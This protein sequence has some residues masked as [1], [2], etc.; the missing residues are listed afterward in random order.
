MKQNN[1]KALI[2]DIQHLQDALAKQEEIIS[3][4]GTRIELLEELFNDVEET[5]LLP[6]TNLKSKIS[7]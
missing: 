6:I 2:Q 4:L 1:E 5:D 3:E 7:I